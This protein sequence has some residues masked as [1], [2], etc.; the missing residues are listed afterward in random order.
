MQPHL[1]PYILSD[2]AAVSALMPG[3]HGHTRQ[4]HA[5]RVN[6]VLSVVCVLLGT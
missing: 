6:R 5:N 3:M 2:Q 4:K 1:Y